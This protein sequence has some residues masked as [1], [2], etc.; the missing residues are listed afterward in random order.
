[1]S[2]LSWLRG[3]MHNFGLDVVR[4]GEQ[5]T[6]ANSRRLRALRDCRISVALDVGA[7]EGNFGEKLR[8]SGYGGRIISF[9]PL[10]ASYRKLVELSGKDPAWTAVH[11]AI[12]GRDGVSV[13][14]VSGRH[15]SSS[16]LPMAAS[17][18][19]AAPDSQYVA[20]ESA[21][22]ARL[23][24]ALRN[25]VPPG[26]RLYLKIDVQGSE[27][28]VLAGAAATLE[29]TDVI[30][31]EVSTLPLY[32]GSIL[33][34]QMIAKLDSLGFRLISWEDVL[35]DPQS[36]YVLQADCIFVRSATC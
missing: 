21:P 26:E 32:E 5:K 10:S 35:S 3:L 15:T 9:E 2:R 12:G 30:E 22:I 28:G 6:G 29:S 8:R 23:D 36:G 18:R 1:M 11:T 31:V 13:M 4:Y 7:S 16:L 24:S 17:H 20:T 14:N 27:G 25:L 34:A 33:C 19:A